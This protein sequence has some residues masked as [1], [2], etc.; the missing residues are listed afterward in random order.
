LAEQHGNA[1]GAGLDPNQHQRLIAIKRRACRSA[2]SAR[3]TAEGRIDGHR[4]NIR[5]FEDLGACDVALAGRKTA[6][7]GA[8]R[9][10]ISGAGVAVPPGFTTTARFT[11]TP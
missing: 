9:S 1:R 10:A 4:C 8:L 11:E 5:W 7:L 3:L 6:S 2:H